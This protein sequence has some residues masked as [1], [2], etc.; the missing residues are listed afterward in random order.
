MSLQADFAETFR[1]VRNIISGVLHILFTNPE[2]NV[3][4]VLTEERGKGWKF[5][6]T[7]TFSPLGEREK[8]S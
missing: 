1:E 3:L 7:L 5:N 4:R 2:P 8:Q 6:G